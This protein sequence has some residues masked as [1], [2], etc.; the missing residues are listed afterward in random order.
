MSPCSTV[1]GRTEYTFR[2]KGKRKNKEVYWYVAETE[3][4]EVGTTNTAA[5]SGWTG[6]TLRRSPTM[7]RGASCVWHSNS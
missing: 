7:K 2:R 4:M 3:T 6:T 1:R 5:T